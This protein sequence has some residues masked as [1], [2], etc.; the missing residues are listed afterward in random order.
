MVF[1]AKREL[2]NKH[3][4]YDL[5]SNHFSLSKESLKE[6]KH[7]LFNEREVAKEYEF[8]HKSPDLRVEYNINEF[9]DEKSLEN[10]YKDY[11][12]FKKHFV[13]EVEKYSITFENYRKNT[14][15]HNK[16]E[17]KLIKFLFKA[18]ILSFLKEKVY[19]RLTEEQKK[20]LDKYTEN[21]H[22]KKIRDFI[23]NLR[24][25]KNENL[26]KILEE[27]DFEITILD[28]VI[29]QIT[30]IKGS[31]KDNLKI[32]ISRN[33]IDY[34][35]CS[36]AQSFTSCINMES[37]Y[38][39]A[40]WAGMPGTITDKNRAIAYIT[41]GTTVNY[42]GIIGPKIENRTWVLTAR[43]KS[44]SKLKDIPEKEKYFIDLV[45]IY[46]QNTDSNYSIFYNF[47]SKIFSNRTVIKRNSESGRQDLVGQYYFKPIW[48]KDYRSC[49]IYQDTTRF[50]IGK[51]NKA[52]QT[53][54]F[55]Y[56]SFSA[57]GGFQIISKS[58]NP[59]AEFSFS[60]GLTR[61]IKNETELIDADKE[62]EDDEESCCDSCGTRG[63][64]VCYR[65]SFDRVFC[66][67]CFSE[68]GGYC[69]QCGEDFSWDDLGHGPDDRYYCS[70]CMNDKFSSCDDC[71]EYFEPGDLIEENGEYFCHDCHDN[72]LERKQEEAKKERE[73]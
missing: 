4:V 16:S 61:L 50:A 33:F 8:I 9:L 32:V 42:K 64:D 67:E 59:A 71:E 65:E 40:F 70:S 51:K 25:G 10:T 68:R 5:I 45:K 62:Y 15:S 63:D 20:E 7:N 3:L 56:N 44:I 60:G 48:F 29:K 41:D 57:C 34:F 38:N 13:K 53:P 72:F 52:K 2:S 24:T 43:K 19:D 18:K 11:G 54:L 73:S 39:G 49:F 47:L 26:E 46:P 30:K 37:D 14:L 17:Y 27:I 28:N 36:T 55:Y 6:F 21:T 35:M 66:E 31:T 12:M 1:D 69:E 22:F 23:I 58:G